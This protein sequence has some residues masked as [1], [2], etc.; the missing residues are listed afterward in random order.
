MTDNPL[1]T[2]GE[3]GRADAAAIA[4]GVPGLDLMEAAGVAVA[5][6]IRRRFAPRPVTVLC[7]PGNNGGDGF[8]V[9][10]RL[11]ADGWPVTVA[12]LGAPEKLKGD[13]AANAERWAGAVAP[14]GETALEGC[15]LVV[16]ALFGAGLTRPLDGAAHAAIDE[17]NKRKLDCIAID[18]P[19]G[20]DG[21]TGAV[22]GAA[23]RCVATVTFF[24]AKPGHYLL[25]GRDLA[26]DLTVADIGIPESVLE[27]IGPQTF[28]NGPGLWGDRFPWP[29]AAG[30]K[31]SRGHAV[32]VGGAEMTGA[33]R[34]AAVAARRIGA[35]L[36]TIATPS[37]AAAVYRVEEPGNIVTAIDDDPAFD[38]LLADG[39]RNAVLVGPGAGVTDLTRRRVLSALAAGKACVLDADALSVFRDDPEALFAAINGPCLLTPHEG[40]FHRLFGGL[41]GDGEGTDKLSR[42]RAAAKQSGA[43]VLLKGADTV[44]AA[45]DGVAV[46]NANAPADLASAG[47]G[48]VLAGLAVGLLAQGMAPLDA[49]SAAAWLHGA[50]A[51]AVGPGLIAED[52]AA[53]LGGVLAALKGTSKA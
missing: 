34:L 5:E 27:A 49:A 17:I 3:M 53:A 41:F 42:A 40:E 19:S 23:P 22:L 10:R 32:V 48:D 15:E 7:G 46:I 37:E 16:D 39:R 33:A 20:V 25:P 1:L 45:P 4:G 31:Y 51:R 50:A 12:L 2:V 6:A 24:R 29:E 36:V 47:T 44:I 28:H 26:G 11:A 14:L 43:V 30:N 18:V 35:G 52:L 8:V 9:A 38:A 21:N 13:A